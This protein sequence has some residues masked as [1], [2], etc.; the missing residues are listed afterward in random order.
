M[1]LA[2]PAR[3]VAVV[4]L[5]RQ[6]MVQTH[7]LR[8]SS[9]ERESKT[10]ALYEFIVSEQCAQFFTRLDNCAGDLLELQVKEKKQHEATWKKQGETLRLIQ[11]VQADLSNRISSII[12]T[13]VDVEDETE[14]CQ[15]GT[16]CDNIG[17][18]ESCPMTLLG[19]TEWPPEFCGRFDIGLCFRVTTLPADVSTRCRP[20]YV[21][22]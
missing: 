12:G 8:L 6:H 16:V 2:N 20:R 3:V 14:L 1:L 11:K 15:A 18:P 17:E 9:A 21:C 7:T 4:M 19:G 22:R 13:A 10:A 5:I